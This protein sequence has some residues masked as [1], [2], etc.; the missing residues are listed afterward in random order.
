MSRYLVF[1]EQREGLL[2]KSSLETWNRVQALAADE[3][4]SIPV[5]GVILGPADTQTSENE[6][7]GSGRLFHATAPDFLLY[8]SERYARIVSDVFRKEECSTLFFA[9]TALSRDLA[10]KL[11]IRLEASLLSG[12]ARFVDERSGSCSRSVYAGS[13]IASF[14]AQL[15]KRIFTL[16]SSPEPFSTVLKA[17][18]IVISPFDDYCQAISRP[19][20][21][22]QKIAMTTGMRDVAEA[23]II[24]AGG[25]GIGSREGFAMLEELAGLLGGSVG[26]SRAVVDEGWRPHAEQV[27][28]TGKSVAPLLYLACGISG[29]VQHLAGIGRAGTIVAINSD[30]HAPIFD[31]ADFG[32]VGDVHAVIPGFIEEVRD[33]LKKK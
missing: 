9:D 31:T 33:F 16:F 11:S 10:P 13:C 23:G 32:I 17:G 24:V 4:P 15:E 3:E 1:L 5:C 25:R 28:Q 20:A 22:V 29:S 21:A 19:S 26:A 6:L 8:D 27:G 12:C 30:R 7:Y 14:T 2:R 18:T